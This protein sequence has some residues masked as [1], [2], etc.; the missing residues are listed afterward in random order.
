MKNLLV[1]YHLSEYFNALDYIVLLFLSV[2]IY[3]GAIMYKRK[4]FILNYW[5]SLRLFQTTC[6]YDRYLKFN[7]HYKIKKSGKFLLFLIQVNKKVNIKGYSGWEV[8]TLTYHC[9]ISG[10]IL[11]VSF[12][13][14][15]FLICI[16]L[17]FV[18]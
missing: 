3:G 2:S 7:I 18:L 15:L 14:S 12:W 8:K 4:C 6:P 11:E 17:F 13:S 1:S 10:S 9:G 5:I 16:F